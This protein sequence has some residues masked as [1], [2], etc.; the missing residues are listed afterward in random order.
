MCSVM[1]VLFGMSV[2]PAHAQLAPTVVFSE[3]NWG[4]SA[5]GIA[6]EWFEIANVGA[7]PVDV[8]GWSVTG[9]ATGGE[10]ITFPA[11]AV[12]PPYSTY[13]VSNY[14][15][16]DASTLAFT[17]DLVTT[18]VSIPNTKITATLIAADGTVIDSITDPSTPDFGSSI[19]PF[20]SMERD[21]A[22]L[23]WQAPTESMNLTDSTQLGTPGFASVPAQIAEPDVIDEPVELTE[24]TEVPDDALAPTVVLED[25]IAQTVVL[26]DVI[27]EEPVVA[28]V[29]AEEPIVEEV[30]VPEEIVNEANT[31][32]LIEDP[33]VEVIVEPAVEIAPE[34][35]IEV[36]IDPV[37]EAPV[38][39]ID[40]PVIID[41]D[42]TIDA[43]LEEVLV[44]EEAIEEAA[45]E[46]IPEEPS[47]ASA[48]PTTPAEEP[49]VVEESGDL[50]ATEAPSDSPIAGVEMPIT[51]GDV[52]LNE[53]FVDG[54][55]WI[56]IRNA[57]DHD[58]DV[59]GWSV[60]DASGKATLLGDYVLAPDALLVVDAP[61]G[62]LNNDSDVV[63][64]L[65]A[66]GAV[67]DAIEYGT[68]S[69]DAPDAD[70]SLVRT[71]DGW[72][73]LTAITKGTANAE[74]QDSIEESPYGNGVAVPSSMG[75][76]ETIAN[77]PPV[78]VAASN[79]PAPVVTADA[80]TSATS[81]T[82][83]A[84]AVATKNVAK[85][86]AP[87]ASASV[88]TAGA[89]TAKKSSATKK[90]TATT[91][92]SI[93]G[94]A[95]GALVRYTGTVIALPDTF[96]SQM[97][98]L[99]GAA[100]YFYYA[101]WPTLA[102]GD[103]VTVIGEISTAR[104]ERRIKVASA[105]N[106][107]LGEHVT[108]TVVDV[109]AVD[110]TVNAQLVRVKGTISSREGDTLMLT[111]GDEIIRVVA[112]EQSGVHWSALNGSRVAIAGVVRHL[113]GE[114]VL[115]PR[116]V[117]D[118]VVEHD[119]IIAPAQSASNFPTNSV[120]GGSM[121]ASIAGVLAYWFARSRTLIP[122]V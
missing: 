71:A 22:T 72:L 87:K 29:I 23:A 43:V 108:P 37:V 44:I 101:D 55:E 53:V 12:I 107:T 11:G 45:V 79:T 58:I 27:A 94:L 70:E 48:P 113:D 41:P 34:L 99:S 9:M 76:T 42:F 69:I 8:G 96:G 18:V 81:G 52:Q 47:V 26:E 85:S 3:L 68:D 24:T 51:T 19:A 93:D 17:P 103:V 73:V 74:L 38:E 83:T 66:S 7:E 86:S 121:L 16:G 40:E 60:R 117:D 102:I 90:K 89:K 75:S 97:L 35:T 63:E 84:A 80:V 21:F 10:V 119:E 115:M 6:D 4:G 118:V 104:G 13:L 36:V 110:A 78:Y 32:I 91:V 122:S 109:T 65:D 100:V 33:V 20:A 14:G 5:R 105:A 112:S 116:S 61:K 49:V 106:M 64:L 28:D 25:N 82:P 56:E 1:G 59:T 114:Y 62:K 77:N 30:I 50:A 95:D 67:V 57:D 54:D 2:L 92:T 98:M 111:V 88:K 46:T 120:V 15:V 39:S 31:T